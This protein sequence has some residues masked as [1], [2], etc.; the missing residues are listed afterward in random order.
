KGPADG[1]ID[2]FVAHKGPQFILNLRG[3]L[4][5]FLPGVVGV[6]VAEYF[7][8]DTYASAEA[9]NSDIILAHKGNLIEKMRK[10]QP[11]N[12]MVIAS[13]DMEENIENLDVKV[14]E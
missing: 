2:L 1:G 10:Y 7:T 4:E 14:A 3:A 12:K 6:L 5:D 11:Q 13:R 8:K 9:S